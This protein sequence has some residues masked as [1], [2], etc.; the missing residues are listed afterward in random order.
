M[1]AVAARALALS[2]APGIAVSDAEGQLWSGLANLGSR[3]G[4][5]GRDRLLSGLHKIRAVPLFTYIVSYGGANHVAQGSHSNFTGFAMTWASNIPTTALPSLTPVLRNELVHKAYRGTFSEVSG[6]KHV[7]RNSL[8]LG[9]RE[10]TVVAV[11]T[12]R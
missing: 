4:A 9:G 5:V 11:Q 6:V 7:W 2:R 10:M 8:E 12:E 3:P 1:R